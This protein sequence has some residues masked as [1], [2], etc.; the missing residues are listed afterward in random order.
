MPVI[1]ERGNIIRH[2]LFSVV[3]KAVSLGMYFL[4][5]GVFLSA[6]AGAEISPPNKE[7]DKHIIEKV[8]AAYAQVED[9]QMETEV[10]VYHDG[11][12]C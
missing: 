8:K 4:M 3:L 11:Q 6:A 9:Y 5:Q 10:K 2:R 12:S 1:Q 7:Y